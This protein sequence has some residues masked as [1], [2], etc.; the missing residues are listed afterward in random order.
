MLPGTV[1]Q[2]SCPSIDSKPKLVGV[3]RSEIE[4]AKDGH[5]SAIGVT[6][7]LPVESEYIPVCLSCLG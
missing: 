1:M 3:F 5:K 6:A 4:K 2:Q 7:I